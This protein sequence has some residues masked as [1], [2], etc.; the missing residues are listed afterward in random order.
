MEKVKRPI[1][2]LVLDEGLRH[3]DLSNL[4][5]N[6]VS[7]DEYNSKIDDSA[8]VIAFHVQDRSAAQDLNRF[9]QKSYVEL[10][11]TDISPAPDTKGFYIVFVELPLNSD[12]GQAIVNITTDITALA[13]IPKWKMRLRTVNG[14][15]PLDIS[16]IEEVLLSSKIKEF[17]QMSELTNFLFEDHIIKV[18]GKNSTLTFK[19]NEIVESNYLTDLALCEGAVHMNGDEARMAKILQLMLGNGYDVEYIGEN[20]VVRSYNSSKIL[21][22]SLL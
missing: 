16:K 2:S 21:L 17:F 6:I 3:D 18:F 11:D 8:I 4:V 10:L 7:I 13:N 1:G 19:F 15:V 5:S 20:I 9:I 22:G 12:I 14:S